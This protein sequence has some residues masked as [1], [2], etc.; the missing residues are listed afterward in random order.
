MLQLQLVWGEAEVSQSMLLVDLSH[1]LV[2]Y[3][4]ELHEWV[5]PNFATL[6]QG[7]HIKV[8]AVASRWQRVGDLIGSKFEPRT[9]RT[10]SRRLPLLTCRS[11]LNITLDFVFLNF[12][13]NRSNSSFVDW[14]SNLFQL[15]EEKESEGST[16]T[17]TAP[18]N[19]ISTTWS[20]RYCNRK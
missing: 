3:Y 1:C 18:V 15:T 17:M 10:R 6:R 12:T 2:F 5:V 8:A 16:Q 9:S 19:L 4:T 7:L 11:T 20:T 14:C 13:D